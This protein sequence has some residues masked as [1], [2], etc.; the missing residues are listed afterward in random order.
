MTD[1]TPRRT[2]AEVLDYGSR[3]RS[4]GFRD[5]LNQTGDAPKHILQLGELRHVRI[6]QPR[7]RL[8]SGMFL[9]WRSPPVNGDLGELRCQVAIRIP[10]SVGPS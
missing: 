4:G 6:V 7:Q 8:A 2:Y 1:H 5:P 9:C 3:I 10:I